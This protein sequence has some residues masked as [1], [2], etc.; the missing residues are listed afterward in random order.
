[1]GADIK[2]TDS[3]WETICTY[4]HKGSLNVA[5]QECGYKILSKWYRTPSLLHKFSCSTTNR[6]WRCDTEEGTLLHI[7]WSCPVIQT[8]W[9]TVHDTITLITSHINDFSPATYL[10]H[11]TKTP[12][13]QYLKS[14]N[15]FMI[16]AARQCIPC[17]WRSPAAPTREEWYRRL[18]NIEKIEELISIS[19]ETLSKFTA[20]WYSWQRFF[21]SF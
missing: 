20:T 4:I 1:M 5:T 11:L 2:R 18:N 19:H 14:L 17:H 7:W 10:L 13:R 12:K 21:L 15:M 3:E 8:F 6:C 16:N 9:R